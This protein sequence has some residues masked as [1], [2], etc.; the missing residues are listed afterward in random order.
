MSRLLVP[1]RRLRWQLTL[2]YILI[3][4]VAGFTLDVA[5]TVADVLA[6]PKT[7]TATPAEILVNA[8]FFTEGPQIAPY[9]E[10]SP[11]AQHGLTVWAN[12]W[13]SGFT[14]SKLGF[15]ASHG[16]TA[17]SSAQIPPGSNGARTVA[18]VIVGPDGHMLASAAAATSLVGAVIAN[19][20]AQTA[21]HAAL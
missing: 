13:A 4:L 14:F 5:T 15:V 20:Q 12:F 16:G 17:E 18:V 1:F 10:Q 9:L 3:T 2:S 21:L 19:P 8:M 6:P 7:P 11:P